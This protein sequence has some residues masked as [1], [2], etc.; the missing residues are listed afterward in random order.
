MKS[1]IALVAVIV[2]LLTAAPVPA[3]E[4]STRPGDAV[5]G[6]A[7]GLSAFRLDREAD[8]TSSL[9]VALRGSYF[10]SERWAVGAGFFLDRVDQEDTDIA[11]GRALAELML[12]PIPD[13]DLSPF[14]RVGAG[15]SRWTWRPGEG[16]KLRS[17][18]LTAEGAVGF[19]AFINEYF[20]VTV[21]AA[22]FYDRYDHNPENEDAHNL[23]ATIGFVGFLR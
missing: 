23:S 13:A 2:A 14:L 5:L 19:F 12:V 21:D 20:A 6:G 7:A 16:D 15:Y 10:V 22:Y 18:A 17:E 1:T 3:L 8:R 9:R 4:V 11:T